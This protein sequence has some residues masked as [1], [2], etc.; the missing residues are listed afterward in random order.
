MIIFLPQSIKIKKL[1]FSNLFFSEGK[2][3]S[4]ILKT[5]LHELC[6]V[7]QDWFGLKIIPADF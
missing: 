1:E 5:N 6:C 2:N 3:L 4:A 7:K